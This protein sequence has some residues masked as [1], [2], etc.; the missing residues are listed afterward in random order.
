M[1]N[2]LFVVV[3]LLFG[4]VPSKSLADA[5]AELQ[6]P[7]WKDEM[8]ATPMPEWPQVPISEE[9][10]ARG[11][12][13][14]A[15]MFMAAGQARTGTFEGSDVEIITFPG[16]A[17]NKRRRSHWSISFDR[18]KNWVRLR[19][20][21]DTRIFQFARNG[22]EALF[23]LTFNNSPAPRSIH[24]HPVGWDKMMPEA[25]PLDFRF[26]GVGFAFGFCN[27][28]DVEDWRKRLQVSLVPHLV[29]ISE[30]PNGHVALLFEQTTGRPFRCVIWLDS[31]EHTR[32][33]Q[34][35]QW[36]RD[37]S[38]PSVWK[39]N[40]TSRTTWQT[41]GDVTVPT[42]IREVVDQTVLRSMEVNLPWTMVNEALPKE[43]VSFE[44]FDL[45][46]GTQVIN[47]KS[48]KRALESI[49]GQPQSP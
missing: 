34:N 1:N 40:H 25:K 29:G 32:F 16:K 47:H 11:R 8:L 15:K 49:I 9:E 28:L 44:S 4:L 19:R 3:A 38:E 13:L 41:I 43:S 5:K 27:G 20:E 17:K 14:F 26:A 39:V 33:I 2:S 42:Q 21:K 7:A 6:H 18:P 10:S 48:G 45:P 31:H 12:R 24:R 23:R 30:D 22:K 36:E 46:P 37:A 35:A